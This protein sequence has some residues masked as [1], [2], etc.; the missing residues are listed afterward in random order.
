MTHPA[1]ALMIAASRGRITSFR[2]DLTKHDRRFIA[3]KD[4]ARPFVWAI[5]AS[6]THLCFVDADNINGPESRAKRAPHTFPAMIANSFD[7]VVY[8]KWDGL[9]LTKLESVQAA[10]DWCRSVMFCTECD[11]PRSKAHAP[12]GRCSGACVECGAT[13]E[14]GV[15]PRSARGWERRHSA[16]G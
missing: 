4:P 12:C 5:H 3:D 6:G 16:T 15:C 13:L 10:T 2:T 1:Y 14:S 7:H 9:S 11:A 8:Y